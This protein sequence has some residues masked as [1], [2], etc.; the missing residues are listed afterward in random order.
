MDNKNLT[1]C[2]NCAGKIVLSLCEHTMHK[3]LTFCSP[4]CGE[5]YHSSDNSDQPYPA[6]LAYDMGLEECDDY[7]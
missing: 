5:T 3:G 4:E 6:G 1:L 2:N 7:P